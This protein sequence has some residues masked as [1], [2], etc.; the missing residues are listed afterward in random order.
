MG[1]RPVLVTIRQSVP[2]VRGP[3]LQAPARWHTE[4]GRSE[5][6]MGNSIG[7][8]SVEGHHARGDE[9]GS[10]GGQALATAEALGSRPRRF[11][12]TSGAVFLR[13]GSG[14]CPRLWQPARFLGWKL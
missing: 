4:S 5:R 6:L 2:A 8:G 11:R 10:R 3:L 9:G 14:G 12:D 1:Y 13:G 7:S